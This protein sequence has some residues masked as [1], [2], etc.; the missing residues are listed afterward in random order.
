MNVENILKVAALL[1]RVHL[2]KPEGFTMTKFGGGKSRAPQP[3]APREEFENC[4]T[5]GCVAGWAV[6]LYDPFSSREIAPS[7]SD[8]AQKLLGLDNT[9]TDDL[10]CMM[11]VDPDIWGEHALEHPA[12]NAK[13]AAHV[14][15]HLA[16]TGEVD[17]GHPEDGLS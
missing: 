9:Q 15:R 7:V 13:R 5:V 4:G 16:K 2:L 8:L 6:A 14:L 3:E 10:F 11:Y 12:A 1:D 17:W